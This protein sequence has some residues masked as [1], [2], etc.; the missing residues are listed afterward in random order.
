MPIQRFL[1]LLSV[2][3]I[4]KLYSPLYQ[5]WTVGRVVT[6]SNLTPLIAESPNS[7]TQDAT[8]HIWLHPQ[9]RATQECDWREGSWNHRYQHTF[10]GRAY[11]RYCL[12]SK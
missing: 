4:A 1:V 9:Q 8:L 5:I 7:H 11:P 6:T 10:M 3:V 12:E 2:L